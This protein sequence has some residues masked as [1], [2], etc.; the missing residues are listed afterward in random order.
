MAQTQPVPLN[1][2]YGPNVVAGGGLLLNA[3]TSSTAVVQSFHLL[4]QTNASSI[5]VMVAGTGVNATYSIFCI[6]MTGTI[7]T[8]VS[9]AALT[10][11]AVVTPNIFAYYIRDLYVEI[12][13]AS[14]TPGSF[15]VEAWSTGA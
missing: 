10:A 15:V 3:Q 6:D 14:S 11:G 13:P 4:S 2:P 1:L 8:L 7:R 5:S 9:N 12:T